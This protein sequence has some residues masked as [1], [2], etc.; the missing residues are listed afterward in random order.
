M[1]DGADGDGMTEED[2]LTAVLDLA[3][4]ANWR[5]CHFRPARTNKGWRTLV[6]GHT[7]WP[8]LM[9]CGHRRFLVAE[10]KSD[11]GSLSDDQARWRLVLDLAGVEYH[12]WKPRDWLD[13]TIAEALGCAG[14]VIPKREEA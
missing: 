1:A 14:G 10:L 3:M 11:K 6:Q 12:V 13:G 9:L 5:V 7:G 2:L 4:T 8:D